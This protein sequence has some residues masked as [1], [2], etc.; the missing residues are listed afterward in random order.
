MAFRR[1]KHP[2]VMHII[3]LHGGLRHSDSLL[4]ELLLGCHKNL[5]PLVDLFVGSVR[6]QDMSLQIISKL[7][8]QNMFCL[9]FDLFIF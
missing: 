9:L 4:T 6:L 8:I 1:Y 2:G 7:D 5:A 3:L